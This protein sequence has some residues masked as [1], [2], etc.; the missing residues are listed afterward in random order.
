MRPIHLDHRA[1]IAELAE[2]FAPVRVSV[3]NIYESGRA[4]IPRI[5]FSE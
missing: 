4:H 1:L 3:G 5:D 2:P